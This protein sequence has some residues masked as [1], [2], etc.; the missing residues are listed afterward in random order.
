MTPHEISLAAIEYW[1]SNDREAWR[2]L[3]AD[4]FQFEGDVFGKDGWL[5]VLDQWHSAFPDCHMELEGMVC[6]ERSCAAELLFTGTHTGTLRVGAPPGEVDLPPTGKRVTVRFGNFWTTNA[7]G[8]LTSFA[9]YGVPGGLIDS[10]VI[11]GVQ[12]PAG[13]AVQPK[14][15]G[16]GLQGRPIATGPAIPG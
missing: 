13:F 9:A 3:V 16:S 11:P 1:N 10:G 4:D 7:D 15:A 5:A 2:S 8:L 12:L 6:D 14:Y